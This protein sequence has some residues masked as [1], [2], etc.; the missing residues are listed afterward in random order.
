MEP[1]CVQEHACRQAI[2]LA[3]DSSMAVPVAAWSREFVEE[4]VLS[5]LGSLSSSITAT[6]P[7]ADS[8]VSGS[9]SSSSQARDDPAAATSLSGSLLALSPAVLDMVELWQQQ[10]G[11]SA[12]ADSAGAPQ[13]HSSRSRRSKAGKRSRQSGPDTTTTTIATASSSSDLQELTVLTEQ[14]QVGELL[15][16]HYQQ[17]EPADVAAFSSKLLQE[18]ARLVEAAAAAQQADVEGLCQLCEREMPLTKH[19][20]IPRDVHKDFKKRGFGFAEL[21][22]GAMVCRPCHS[23]IHRAVPDNKELG[24]RYR[25]LDALRQHKDIA[26]FAS[27]AR[28]Q[29][30]TSKA[31]VHSSHFKYRR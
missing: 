27:W 13:E 28:R 12:A 6:P 9:S 26:A 31:D 2:S 1:L 21:Q 5:E 15:S 25:T 14:L 3:L 8:S 24:L 10:S 19:H 22:A 7:S 17:V 4:A 16:E 29:R 30:V 23:A 18:L 11:A 20:L